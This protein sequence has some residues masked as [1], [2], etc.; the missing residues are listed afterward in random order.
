MLSLILEERLYSVTSAKKFST[1][2]VPHLGQL[3][4]GTG[5]GLVS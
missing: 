1:C 4:L 2:T 3:T 5:V